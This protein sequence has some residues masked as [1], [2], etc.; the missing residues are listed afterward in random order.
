M[1]QQSKPQSI[2]LQASAAKISKKKLQSMRTRETIIQA[3][4]GCFGND[5]YAGC[6]LDVIAAAAGITKGAIYTH[7]SSKAELFIAIIEHA[8]KRTSDKANE[9]KQHLPYVDAIIELL[10]ECNRNPDFPIDHKLWAEIL[11]MANRDSE[12]RQ[13]FLRCQSDF[14]LVIENWIR[15]GADAGEIK[16]GINI[17]AAAD[18]LF[19]MGNGL[20]V[21]LPNNEAHAEIEDFKIFADTARALLT[22]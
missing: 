18:L 5:G 21:R 10:G 17:A 20:I 6:S 1:Y 2:P 19:V 14:R 8:Y 7:F 9:L 4:A 16:P 11:A 22:P 12:V 13:V 3:A 15:E